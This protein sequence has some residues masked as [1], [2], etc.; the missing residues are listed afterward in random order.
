MPPSS[1]WLSK[2]DVGLGEINR[3]LAMYGTIASGTMAG[4][5][6]GWCE[7][8]R[9][10]TDGDKDGRYIKDNPASLHPFSA[11]ED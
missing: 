6:P 11:C 10:I 7:V 1:N 4:Q 5:V 3:D 2:Q 8:L 9:G